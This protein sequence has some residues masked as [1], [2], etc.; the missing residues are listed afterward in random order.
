MRLLC[1]LLLAAALAAPPPSAAEIPSLLTYQGRLATADSVPVATP[2]TMVFRIYDA[3]EGGVALWQ[4]AIP[5]VPVTDGLFTV[6]LGATAPLDGLPFGEAYFLGVAPLGG[7]ECLP[8]L[9][10]R[11]SP[12]A[13]G[14]VPGTPGRQ[15]A[16]RRSGYLGVGV[17][18]ISS[19]DLTLTKF[20]MKEN[21]TRIELRDTDTVANHP[22]GSWYLRANDSSNGGRNAFQIWDETV[23]PNGPSIDGT[24]TLHTPQFSVAG[25]APADSLCVTSVGGLGLGTT[26]TAG[27]FLSRPLATTTTVAAEAAMDLSTTTV[28]VEVASAA[29][30]LGTTG[31]DPLGLTAGGLAVMTVLPDGT[32]EMSDGGSYDG[33]WN[34]A[35]SRAIKTDVAPLEGEAALSIAAALK[36]VRFEYRAAPGDGRVGFIA[37]D[38]PGAVAAPDRHSLREADVVAVLTGTAQQQ[39]TWLNQQ[40]QLIETLTRRLETLEADRKD[41]SK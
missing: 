6:T 41:G 2:T 7:D 26:A 30:T 4:E 11:P 22:V 10:F 14:G 32:L 3:A 33:T 5:S 23:N 34:P 31:P 9:A 24:L 29:V 35:S 36:P 25:G 12:F 28:V 16:H 37:E 19:E 39:Q 27:V 15:G 8:R 18:V 20:L 1:I 38:V 13:L 21:N 40:R 17:D